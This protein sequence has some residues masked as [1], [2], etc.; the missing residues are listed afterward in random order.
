MAVCIHL[1]DDISD[2]LYFPHLVAVLEKQNERRIVAISTSIGLNI[3]FECSKESSLLSNHSICFDL[4]IRKSYY[5]HPLSSG[6]L[7]LY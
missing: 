1:H 3:C 7:H 5:I 4:E 2:Q 6:G